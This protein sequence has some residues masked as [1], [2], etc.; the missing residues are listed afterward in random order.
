MVVTRS[1]I[2]K[3]HKAPHYNPDGT[4]TYLGRVYKHRNQLPNDYL[5]GVSIQ[6]LIGRGWDRLGYSDMIHRDGIIENLTPYNKDQVVDEKEKT[7]GAA[8]V[9]SI[10]RHIMLVGGWSGN[11]RTGKWPFFD[12]F[13]EAQFLSLD[14]YLRRTLKDHPDIKIIGH[15][16]VKGSNKSCPNFDVGKVC[17]MLQV[18]KKN[19]GL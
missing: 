14:E 19:I 18:P 1:M 6:K 17:T 16:Q 11:N 10:S 3:W 9:N 8:G 7:W 4:L 13:T 5:D 2:E 15:Y 12:I